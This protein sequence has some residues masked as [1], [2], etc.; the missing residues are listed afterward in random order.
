MAYRSV[1]DP[2]SENFQNNLRLHGPTWKD[3]RWHPWFGWVP[4]PGHERGHARSAPAEQP[5]VDYD[6]R[7]KRWTQGGRV[8]D[9]DFKAKKYWA[10]PVDGKRRGTMGRLK[11]GLTGEGP[12]VF[13]VLNGDRRTLHRDMPHRAQ[14]SKWKGPGYDVNWW[15]KVLGEDRDLTM[16]ENVSWDMKWAKSDPREKY[17]FQTRE[18]EGPR[19]RFKHEMQGRLWTDAHWPDGAKRDHMNP[20][21]F[22][23]PYPDQWSTRV[24]FGAGLWPG[25]RPFP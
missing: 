21:S 9:K 17:N 25:G 23:G 13:V 4:G 11:D 7:I 3:P 10:R 1:G 6:P 24:G 14:W 22:R 15:S 20:L 16:G 8:L 19:K 12:D 2:Y 5:F 18:Y